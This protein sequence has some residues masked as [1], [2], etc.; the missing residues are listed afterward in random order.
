MIIMNDIM[1]NKLIKANKKEKVRLP[2]ALNRI[3]EDGFIKTTYGVFFKKNYED[4][5]S[6]ISEFW[7]SSSDIEIEVN[8]INSDDY[9]KKD[10]LEKI[11]LF[12]RKFH[13]QWIASEIGLPFAITVSWNGYGY[14]FSFHVIRASIESLIVGIDS[15]Q[16]PTLIII[17]E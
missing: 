17:N 8:E 15:F 13:N 16:V 7:S 6:Y 10:Q 9:C 14:Y 3:I 11:L 12:C 4:N 1:C 5:F 2:V